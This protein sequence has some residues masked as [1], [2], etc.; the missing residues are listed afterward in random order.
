V[1]ARYVYCLVD[2]GRGSPSESPE[3]WSPAGEGSSDDSDG[4]SDAGEAGPPVGDREPDADDRLD[5]TGLDSAPVR[6]VTVGSADGARVG[7][8][9]HD[10]DGL[11]DT[12]DEAQLRRWLLAHQ[13]VV[14]AAAEAFGTPLPVR[15]DTVVEGDDGTLSGWLR[16]HADTVRD[17]L[18]RLAGRREYR[19]GVVW[20]DEGFEAEARATDDRLAELAAE[21]EAADEGRGFLVGKQYDERLR[22]LRA[23]RREALREA[24]LDRIRP[25]VEEWTDSDTAAGPDDAAGEPVASLAVLAP[26]DDEAALGDRLDEY[27]DDHDVTVRFTGPWPPYSFAP[28]LS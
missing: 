27:V 2:P 17:W 6:L 11:Y 24:L 8:V 16:G 23:D 14:D 25:V 13:T 5:V 26:T 4:S 15:F 22:R 3:E 9:V 12:D 21:R 1:S 18:D 7:A 19:V 20:D 10:C 28:E